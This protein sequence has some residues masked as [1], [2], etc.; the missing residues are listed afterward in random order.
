MTDALAA[1]AANPKAVL[2][3]ATADASEGM[4]YLNRLPRRLVTIYLRSEE[5]TSELQSP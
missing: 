4:S 3:G 2:S 1:K 5:H